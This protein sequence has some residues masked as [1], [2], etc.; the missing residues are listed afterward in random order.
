MER[1]AAVKIEESVVQTPMKE[2]ASENESKK[3]KKARTRELKARE[4]KLH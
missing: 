3:E 4:T 1:F 2:R